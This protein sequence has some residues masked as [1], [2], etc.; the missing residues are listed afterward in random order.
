MKKLYLV[1]LFV[2]GSLLLAIGNLNAQ[3]GTL[4]GKVAD[5]A[6]TPVEAAS[7]SV[8]NTKFITLTD[9]KGNYKIENIPAGTYSVVVQ[10]VGYNSVELQAV[11]KDKKTAELNFNL[12][13]KVNQLKKVDVIRPLISAQGMGHMPEL[14]DGVIYSGMKTEILV[15]DSV[16]ANKAQNNPR[17]TLGRL[18]GSNYSETEG[19]GFPSNGIGFR[20]LIPTQSIEIQTR[21]NGYNLSGDVYG[22]PES[23]YLP[24]L[25]AVSRIELINGESSL[26]FGPQFGGVI[27]YVIKDGPLDRP[28]SFGVEQTGASYDFISSVLTGGGSYKKW[29][30][31]GFVQY[32]ATE[33]WRPNSDVTQATA[34]A[35]VEY[36]ASDKL[37]FSLEYTLLRNLIHMPGGLTDAEF[38]AN[39]DQ[40]FRSRNWLSSPWN[41]LTFTGKYKI[42]D[43][44]M[45][46]EQSVMN[47]S[48]RN[49]VWK[50]EDGGPQQPDTITPSLSYVPREVEHEG[51][52]S[53]T[54][55]ARLTTLWH[56][57]NVNSALATGIRYFQGSMTRDEGGPGSTGTNYDMN[58]YGGIYATA[59]NFT[60]T[61][62]APFIENTFHFGKL[63][64]TPGFRFE[65]IKSTA[66]GYN[67][68]GANPLV[69]DTFHVSVA[70]TWLIPLGG[71]ALQYKTSDFTNIYGNIVQAYE[72]TTYENLTPIGTTTIID[73]NLKDVN[74]WNSDLGWRG[75]AGR[76][77]NFDVGGFYMV[78]NQEI[79]LETLRDLNPQKNDSTYQY[80]TNVGDAVHKGI[81]TYVEVHVFKIFSPN[82]KIGDLS[83]FNSYA[84]DQSRY[85]NGPY[86]GNYEEQAPVNIERVGINYSYKNFSTTAVYSYTSVSYADANNTIYDPSAIVGIIPAYTVVDWS[87]SYKI[88]NYSLKF[89]ISNVFNAK[90]FNLRTDEYP[91]PGIIPAPERNFY[92]GLSAQF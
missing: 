12:L 63:S 89:G 68:D 46:T 90:Y 1:I 42:S 72:P 21:Q 53:I 51:F 38:D 9:N 92:V 65:Y 25:V 80:R 83:F 45:L 29:H 50:N 39:P 84:Y 70:R 54:N 59:L 56:I 73:P 10:I 34:F 6:G 64:V 35:K 11:I 88:K 31:Y 52:L 67:S 61:N 32:K 19:S 62:V 57:G 87:S 74:G 14:Y 78:F 49:L 40:S 85:V 58:L 43:K 91:G 18:P 2:I 3:N 20:G 76:F 26:Q 15:L 30:Y 24:P 13:Q 28:W 36:D 16:D 27:N 75:K 4:K 7:I 66:D 17:E 60:T 47:S 23:Y 48:A 41:L 37:T 86:T 69:V 77:I 79:G 44:T 5:S 33:G 8:E 82:P 81:E 22:Y 71:L 55:E